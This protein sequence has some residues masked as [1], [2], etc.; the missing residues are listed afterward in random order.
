MPLF[1]KLLLSK[2][3]LVII[4]VIICLT[5][6]GIQ[7][8]GKNQIIEMQTEQLT[9]CQEEKFY[10]QGNVITLKQAVQDQNKYI[11]DLNTD[12]EKKKVA[13]EKTTLI[14]EK[15]KPKELPE[16]SNEIVEE[17]NKWYAG[18]Y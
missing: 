6:G 11:A 8:Y 17:M 5:I 13:S 9:T 18:L 2:P 10:C 3:G 16:K 4:T 15:K 7:L 14:V 1:L 12:L